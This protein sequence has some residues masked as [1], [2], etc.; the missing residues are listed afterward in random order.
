MARSVRGAVG[1]AA[2]VADTV[3]AA[4]CTTSTVNVPVWART[5]NV[6]AVPLLRLPT[7]WLVVDALLPGIRAQVPQFVPPSVLCRTCQPLMP[8]S[9]EA[10]AQPSVTS[11]SPGVAVRGA[12]AAGRTARLNVSVSV[13]VAAVLT[14]LSVTVYVYAVHTWAMV[15]VPLTTCVASSKPSPAGV[16]LR[17]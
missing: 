2:G 14:S 15:A 4:P 6:Y 9:A 16:P 5:W 7:V 3:A 17:L 12:G 11:V 1:A 8:L 10:S 13:S